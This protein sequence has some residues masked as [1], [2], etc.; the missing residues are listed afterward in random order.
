[1][2]KDK[3]SFRFWLKKSVIILHKIILKQCCESA[4]NA[5][6]DRMKT[7]NLL[8]SIN[9]GCVHLLQ[10]CL[11]SIEQKGGAESYEVYVLH[12]DL[13]T[14]D[15]MTVL[16]TGL[17]GMQYHF[18][19]VP[20]ELFK[21]F[22]VTKRYPE[23][24]YYRLAAPLLLPEHLDRILYLDVDTIIINSLQTLYESDFGDDWFMACTNTGENL[25]RLNRIRLGVD[26]DDDVPYVNTGVLLMN[27]EQLRIHLKLED[28]QAYA[29]DKKKI[30]ILPDQ[31]ILT[32]LYG[33]HVK[34]LER[35]VYNLSDRTL[36]AHNADL[37][38]TRVDLEWVRK[39]AVIIHYFGRN[40]PWH[41]VYAGILDVFYH[42]T[43]ALLQKENLCINRRKTG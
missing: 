22:P 8:F 35:M 1:M 32:A 9:R 26:V 28:I 38:N 19:S 30:L 24:I 29:Q 37:R 36:I 34:I 40:K 14:E 43:V 31:D 39:Y 20:E 17:K 41:D 11:K 5:G 15:K 10:S 33:D 7:M 16:A 2:R 18:V 42:E 25:T 13:T 21:G 3:V 27:L 4:E 6:R 23:Q 12:S